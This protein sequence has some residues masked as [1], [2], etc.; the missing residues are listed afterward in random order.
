MTFLKSLLTIKL[1]QIN[2]DSLAIDMSGN[3]NIYSWHV[4]TWVI[5]LEEGSRVHL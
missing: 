1:R 2:D 4:K 5:G 3:K